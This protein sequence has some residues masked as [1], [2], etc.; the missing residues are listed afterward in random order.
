MVACDSGVNEIRYTV[1]VQPCEVPAAYDSGRRTRCYLNHEVQLVIHAISVH[2]D[3]AV[4][5]PTNFEPS[6]CIR[7]PA[8]KKDDALMIRIEIGV[9]VGV[10]SIPEVDFGPLDRCERT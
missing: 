10:S 9:V 5:Q 8:G 4:A 6:V 1:D 7:H 2:I 3:V